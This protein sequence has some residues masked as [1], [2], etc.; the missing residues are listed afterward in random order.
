M[1]SN[2]S[3]CMKG[4]IGSRS[5]LKNEY[6][7][8]KFL[9]FPL[10][11]LNSNSDK[12]D[13]KS[14]HF[15]TLLPS[16]SHTAISRHFHPDFIESM[17]SAHAPIKWDTEACDKLKNVPWMHLKRVVTG[18]SERAHSRGLT[19]VTEDFMEGKVSSAQ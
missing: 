2:Y 13:E 10:Q 1:I 11:D 7:Y 19:T 4:L 9:Y 8:K 18:V 3:S 14:F 15:E 6:T 12:A 16:N 5:I 17:T